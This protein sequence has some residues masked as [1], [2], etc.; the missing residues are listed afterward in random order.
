MVDVAKVNRDSA[1]NRGSVVQKGVRRVKAERLAKADLVP[2]A[3]RDRKAVVRAAKVIATVVENGAAPVV[4][5]ANVDRVEIADVDPAVNAAS[6]VEIAENGAVRA[7]VLAGG[8]SIS[9]WT[10]SSK[11]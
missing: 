10:S 6:V 11:S 5:A 3:A 7:V 1:A 8:R 2:K 9:R 4:L